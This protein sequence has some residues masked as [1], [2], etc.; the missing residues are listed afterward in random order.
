M[1]NE[2]L[3]QTIKADLNDGCEPIMVIGTAG[4]VSTGA[5]DNLKAIASVCKTYG[6]WFHID[7]AYGLPAA[8]SSD[9][10]NNV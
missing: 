10:K 7:G 3:E 4:D 9:T 2:V 8:V 1:D 6:L 5:V